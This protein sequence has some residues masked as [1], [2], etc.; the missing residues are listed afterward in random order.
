[1]HFEF[2]LKTSGNLPDN[3]KHELIEGLKSVLGE[4]ATI[5]IRI[6][7]EIKPQPSGKRP[8][9]VNEIENK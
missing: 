8:L 6:L 2:R 4:L 1:M 5:D 9:Y 7:N 3:T